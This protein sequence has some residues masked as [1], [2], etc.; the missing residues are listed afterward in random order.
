M[1][2]G[3][4]RHESFTSDIEELSLSIGIDTN[5]VTNTINMDQS[6]SFGAY[7]DK[8]LV[9][10][11]TAYSFDNSILIN[12]LYYLKENSEEIISRLFN[13]LLTNIQNNQKTILFMGNKQEEKILTTL[14]FK[15]YA[16]FTKQ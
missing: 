6:L 7:V 10:L 11:I 13:I 9:G 15:Q 14:G 3:W 2:V 12:S 16:K 5:L 1:F 8:K 4:I